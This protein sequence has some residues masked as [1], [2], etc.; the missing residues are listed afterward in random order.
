[1]LQEERSGISGNKPSNTV[2]LLVSNVHMNE[3]E[4]DEEDEEAEEVEK[5]K[6]PTPPPKT[7]VV[8]TNNTQP[9]KAKQ[10]V[11]ETIAPIKVKD[12]TYSSSAS[13]KSVY[14][15]VERPENIQEQRLKLPIVME[16]QKIMETINENL[17]TIL[18]GETGSG[19]T[20]QLPQ[21]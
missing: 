13:S 2:S 21:V 8:A 12:T 14:V 19:K 20:T 1:M 11:T 10:S 7:T 18:C 9:T 3:D 15:V 17:I 4:E 16:E 6:I 5:P